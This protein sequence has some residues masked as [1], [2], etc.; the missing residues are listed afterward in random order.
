MFKNKKNEMTLE[1]IHAESVFLLKKIV[2]FCDKNN[3]RYSLHAGSLLGAVRH[4]G[5]IPWDDDIDIMMPRKDLNF[6]LDN[7]Y[8]DD[9]ESYILTS[10]KNKFSYYSIPKLISKRTYGYEKNYF[11]KIKSY[12]VFVDIFPLD[13]VPEDENFI[14]KKMESNYK[15][16]YKMLS[17]SLKFNGIK[18]FM[19]FFSW[20]FD[21]KKLIN[22]IKFPF[23][24]IRSFFYRWIIGSESYMEKINGCF[25]GVILPENAKLMFLLWND[26]KYNQRLTEDQFDN[27]IKLQFEGIE[28]KVIKD[29][30][31]FLKIH[32]NGDYMVLPDIE[33]RVCH[34]NMVFYRK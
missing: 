17:I 25:E 6:L 29:Y 8:D 23:I 24:L 32:F 10:E 20:N 1:E 22:F 34:H 16:L 30:H 15:L 31:N 7:Y 12:G 18:S 13:K 3:L 9:D 28:C 26:W 4:K 19:L 2:D 5:F 27:A 33:K 14:V 21:G 11:K